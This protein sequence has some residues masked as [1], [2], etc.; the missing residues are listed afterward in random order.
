MFHQIAA[1]LYSKG[2]RHLH[3]SLATLF[4]TTSSPI[5]NFGGSRSLQFVRYISRSN[6]LR[7]ED[8]T[9]ERVLDVNTSHPDPGNTWKHEPPSLDSLVLGEGRDSSLWRY[10]R[11]MFSQGYTSPCIR[12]IFIF[13]WLRSRG[14]SSEWS[15]PIRRTSFDLDL[16]FICFT[17]CSSL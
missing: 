7:T 3:D 12:C 10:N 11:V 16:R 2:T 17:L 8:Q 6:L 5:L 4:Y 14:K 9:K 15:A 1:C 13:V